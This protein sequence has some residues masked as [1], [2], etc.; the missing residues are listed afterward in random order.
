MAGSSFAPARVDIGVS[1]G[2]SSWYIFPTLSSGS[3]CQAQASSEGKSSEL[4]TS[5][6]LWFQI[7]HCTDLV[8][9]KRTLEHLWLANLGTR[10]CEEEVSG[11]HT[12]VSFQ[13][14]R[15]LL[16]T[17]KFKD[18]LPGM[19]REA[20]PS[21]TVSTDFTFKLSFYGRK[22]GLVFPGQC[23]CNNLEQYFPKKGVPDGLC[24]C[25]TVRADCRAGPTGSN[26]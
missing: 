24:L 10:T 20:E 19:N 1:K 23:V 12:E 13:H 8:R 9:G 17:L 6:C 2:E 11:A 15:K 14:G 4:V 7:P 21:L 18:S 5:K 22:S 16:Q 3:L 25:R 26:H